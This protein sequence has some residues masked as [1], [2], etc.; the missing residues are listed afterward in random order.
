M[1]KTMCT[2]AEVAAQSAGKPL[3]SASSGREMAGRVVA[4]G[5]KGLGSSHLDE[6]AEARRRLLPLG[7]R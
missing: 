1:K 6:V 2:Q 4:D 3:V 7:S 5:M